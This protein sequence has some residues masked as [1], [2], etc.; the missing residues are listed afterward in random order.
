M[1]KTEV[2][3]IRKEIEEYQENSTQELEAYNL[4]SELVQRQFKNNKSIELLKNELATYEQNQ[5][6]TLIKEKYLLLKN[7]LN[8]Y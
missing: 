8:G 1:N 6:D 7:K 5:A 2:D 3:S 4:K